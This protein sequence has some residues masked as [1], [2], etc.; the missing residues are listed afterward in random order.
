MA[1]SSETT[2]A[3]NILIKE[4]QDCQTMEEIKNLLAIWIKANDLHPEEVQTFIP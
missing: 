3:L 1:L 4:I 2:G